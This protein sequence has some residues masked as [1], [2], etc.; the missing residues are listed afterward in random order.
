[1]Q[2]NKEFKKYQFSIFV[3]LV[4]T[5]VFSRVHGINSLSD[6]T[7][8]FAFDAEATDVWSR[9]NITMPAIQNSTIIPSNLS[10]IDLSA[11]INPTRSVIE[12][13]SGFEPTQRFDSDFNSTLI[14]RAHVGNCSLR[15]VDDELLLFLNA[16]SGDEAAIAVYNLSFT[17][18]VLISENDFISFALSTRETYNSNE[19]Y[20]GVSLLLRDQQG[21]R[22]YVSLQISN[23]YYENSFGLREWFLGW[24]FGEDYPQYTMRYN[25]NNNIT[26]GP[27]FIQLPL[28]DSFT[29]LNLSSA[30]LDG[31]LIGGEIYSTP[32][33]NIEKITKVNARFHYVL[34]HEQ[35]FMINQEIVNSTKMVFP[36]ASSLNFSGILGERVNVMVEGS[37]KPSYDKEERSENETVNIRE[38]FFNLSEPLESGVSLQKRRGH[39]FVEIAVSSKAVKECTLTINNN[40]TVDLTNSLL[41]SNEIYYKLPEDTILLKVYL[42]LYRFNAWFFSSRTDL[43]AGIPFNITK[44]GIVEEFFSPN[45]NEGIVK[46]NSSENFPDNLAIRSGNLIP[47]EITSNGS[48]KPLESLL[49]LNKQNYW[50]ISIAVPEE[51]ASIYTVKYTLSDG[52]LYQSLTTTPFSVYIDNHIFKIFTSFNV[53]GQEGTLIPLTIRTYTHTRTFTLKIEYDS[54]M[55]EA[56]RDEIMVYASK[57]HYEYFMLKPLRTGQ[58]TINLKII[59]PITR[60]TLFFSPFFISIKSS[61]FTQVGIYFLLGVAV[62]SLIYIFSKTSLI[63][64]ISHFRH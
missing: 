34:V 46:I 33:F 29:S 1:L 2:V 43:V 37:L 35:P 48:K 50:T 41:R 44:K 6:M 28:S 36:V 15:K 22:Y 52:P 27:W 26:S 25:Y 57:F 8:D 18:S 51:N 11:Q 42:T 21:N 23:R 24:S 59:D 62:F 4:L 30:W 12:V 63:K 16:S 39:A 19:A 47:V 53:E 31:L 58:T 54:S 64:W 60:D 9:S 32:P 7:T 10:F 13:V 3:V 20:I 14:R 40:T 5:I 38:T 17:N 55:F 56:D 45:K 49:I 61:F